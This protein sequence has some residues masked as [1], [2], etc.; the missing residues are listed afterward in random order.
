[1]A[2]KFGLDVREMKTDHGSRNEIY[3][4]D[5]LYSFGL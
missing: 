3:D 1:M 5:E 4:N 2:A